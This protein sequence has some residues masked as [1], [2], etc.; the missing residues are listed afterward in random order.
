MKALLVYPNQRPFLVNT[1]SVLNY[2]KAFHRYAL[3]IKH[4][5][6][7]W[8]RLPLQDYRFNDILTEALEGN[9]VPHSEYHLHVLCDD[10]SSELSHRFMQNTTFQ[11][12]LA[13]LVILD[14]SDYCFPATLVR[15]REYS[16]YLFSHII[17]G[18]YFTVRGIVA[19]LKFAFTKT[20]T[21]RQLTKPSACAFIMGVI[22]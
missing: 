6:E 1:D 5:R 15:S 19:P 13:C 17:F 10:R 3:V 14:S 2:P 7:R 16:I 9:G 11:S 8:P 18:E 4:M 22:V 21:K 20:S 12:L